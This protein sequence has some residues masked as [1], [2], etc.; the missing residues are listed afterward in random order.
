MPYL[1]R[2]RFLSSTGA[3]AALPLLPGCATGRGSAAPDDAAVQ[4]IL[5]EVADDLLA[6]FPEN[7]T[8]LGL[9]KDARADLKSRLTNRNRDA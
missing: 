4:A 6:E 1:D 5:A 9:D 8:S 2:R 3:L 7:A